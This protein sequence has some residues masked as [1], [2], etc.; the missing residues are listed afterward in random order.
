MATPMEQAKSG[1]LLTAKLFAGAGVLT[2]LGGGLHHLATQEN[3]I[4]GIVMIVVAIAILFFTVRYWAKWFFGFCSANVLRILVM[5]VSGRTTSVPSIAAPRI[6]FLEA[7]GAMAVMAVLTFRFV[8]HRP[9]RVDAVC[10]VGALV[11]GLEAV[12]TPPPLKGVLVAISFLAGAFTY[13]RL[14]RPSHRRR[15]LTMPHTN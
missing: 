5:A 6:V 8:N 13:H 12:L 1:V 15:S 10:L 9:N 11:A 3:L 7:A 2:L 4:I 14:R